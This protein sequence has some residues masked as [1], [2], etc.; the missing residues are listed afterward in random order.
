MESFKEYTSNH[1]YT[2]PVNS[3]FHGIYHGIVIDNDDPTNG[4]RVKIYIPEVYDRPGLAGSFSTSTAYDFSFI[5]ANVAAALTQDIPELKQ[6]LPWAEPCLPIMGGNNAGNYIASN[7]QGYGGR[8]TISDATQSAVQGLPPAT[9]D[10]SITGSHQ[11]GRITIAAGNGNYAVNTDG[12]AS[13]GGSGTYL[14]NTASGIPNDSSILG[15]TIL[16]NQAG[17]RIVD[18][19]I[20]QPAIITYTIE[21][22]PYRFLAV[23]NDSGGLNR[24]GQARQWGE[25]GINTWQ[26]LIGAGAPGVTASGKGVSLPAGSTIQYDFLPGSVSTVEEYET[27]KTQLENEGRLGSSNLSP[28]L[29]RADT[30]QQ[31]LSAAEPVPPATYL[32]QFSEVDGFVWPEEAGVGGSNQVGSYYTPQFFGNMP[33]GQFSVPAVGAFLWVFFK[34]G[35]SSKPVYVGAMYGD[36]DI[37]AIHGVQGG[38]NASADAPRQTTEQ[39]SDEQVGP[40]G[41]TAEPDLPPIRPP[42]DGSEYSVQ[43]QIDPSLLPAAEPI[44]PIDTSEL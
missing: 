8:G 34:G 30:T 28:E 43:P 23:A 6:R 24:P 39:G 29:L 18:G 44:P 26:A 13:T 32:E 42:E 9:G 11:S 12:A 31:P 10:G 7:G 36:T 3:K 35:D 4:G 25:I 27:L 21:G 14:P 41:L 16:T 22:K 5:G 15:Y 19:R 17:T 33:K 1:G 20:K 37:A 38:S 40:S 2:E